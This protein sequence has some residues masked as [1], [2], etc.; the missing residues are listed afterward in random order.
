MQGPPRYPE[1]GSVL[2]DLYNVDQGWPRHPGPPGGGEALII[3][4]LAVLGLILLLCCCGGL[5]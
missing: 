1:E 2:M 4:G 3:M 5:L